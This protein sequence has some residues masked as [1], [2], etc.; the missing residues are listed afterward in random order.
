MKL[1][2]VIPV[3]NKDGRGVDLTKKAIAS[4][5]QF[6]QLSPDDYEIILIDNASPEHLANYSALDLRQFVY[7]DAKVISLPRNVGFG[8]ACNLGFRLAQ[9][10]YVC[11]MN[12]DAELVEDSANTLIDFME[13]NDIMVAFPE[14]YENCKHYKMEKDERIMWHWYFGCFWVSKR[15]F[16]YGQFGGFDAV[17]FPMCYYEDTDLWSRVLQAGHRVAGY[18]GTWVKHAGNASCVGN[19]HE[20]AS[21]NKETYEKKWGMSR[22][23]PHTLDRGDVVSR[24]CRSY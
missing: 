18:R 6:T 19:I 17:N 12:S 16:I 20:I 3:Y 10:T 11:C 23:I 9:G 24:K 2:Y 13:N 15:D 4:I 1:S 22:V 14:H 7:Q 21:K 5:K 8:A